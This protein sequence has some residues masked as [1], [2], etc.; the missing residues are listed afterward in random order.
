MIIFILFSGPLKQ[1]IG[2]MLYLI[3]LMNAL[4]MQMY[5]EFQNYQFKANAPL[6][7]VYRVTKMMK[8]TGLISVLV[9]VIPSAHFLLNILFPSHSRTQYFYLA[10]DLF[11]CFIIFIVI[12]A[13]IIVYSKTMSKFARKW[14]CSTLVFKLFKYI[15]TIFVDVWP[16]FRKHKKPKSVT[17]QIQKNKQIFYMTSIKSNQV[18][19]QQVSAVENA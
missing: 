14:I 8:K 11:V 1:M 19:P 16:K 7:D 2:N 12:P 5:A 9:L 10:K 15:W 6:Q 18:E 13:S 17:K 4:A 3:L